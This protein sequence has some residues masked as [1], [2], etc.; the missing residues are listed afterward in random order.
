MNSS[1][2]DLPLIRTMILVLLSHFS[3]SSLGYTICKALAEQG[4][5]IYATTTSKGD[6]LL[7]ELE[8]VEKLTH[9]SKGSVTL[10]QPEHNGGEPNVHWISTSPKKYFSY[11]WDL[12]EV[13]GVIGILPETDQTAINITRTLNCKLFIVAHAN[14]G[15]S[16]I[17]SFE[18]VVDKANAFLYLDPRSLDS[19]KVF[20]QKLDQAFFDEQ[21]ET[22]TATNNSPRGINTHRVLILLYR[23]SELGETVF[24]FKLCQKLVQEGY[25]LYVTTTTPEGAQLRAEKK[26]AEQLSQTYSGS[27]TLL[28]PLH[29]K[30]FEGWTSVWVGKRYNQYFGYLSEYG[31]VKTTIGVL[32]GTA[33]TAVKLKDI[34]NCN[35][36]LLAASKLEG[37]GNPDELK[38]ELVRIGKKADEIWCVGPDVHTYYQNIFHESKIQCKNIMFQP[39]TTSE[40]YWQ[41]NALKSQPHSRGIIKFLSVW[42]SPYPFYY[43]GQCSHSTG[44][45]FQ[46][47][48]TLS[49]ALKGIS[50]TGAHKNKIQ[51]DIYGL[52]S[53]LKKNMER[54]TKPT[55]FVLSHLPAVSCVEQL[56][57]QN[58]HSFLVPDIHEESLNFLALCTMWLGIPTIVPSTSSI[59]K[60]LE[61]LNCPQK[62]RAIIE[63]SG[64]TTTDMQKWIQKI[65]RDVLN[66]DARPIQWAKEICEHLHSRTQLWKLNL[67]ILVKEHSLSVSEAVDVKKV[68]SVEPRLHDTQDTSTS[69]IHSQVRWNYRKRNIVNVLRHFVIK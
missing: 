16:H 23:F 20:L 14:V 58:C 10:F 41:I 46:N 11:L 59:G 55:T 54:Q 32:P 52:K 31:D 18:N 51:W 4:H 43:M 9:D 53:H 68:F 47:Y 17:T 69:S 40:D 44:S 1:L 42:S 35:L 63:L 48:C 39:L 57:W 30:E 28:E 33:N 8:N 19:I 56:M 64:S 50:A 37:L 36:V 24:G 7:S 60:L 29:D 38:E 49:S 21:R 13:K 34:L 6:E 12:D 61:Q 62:N 45:S 65:Y 66:K 25:H 22:S 67:A 3:E 27:I 5:H 2:L 15:R 26:K